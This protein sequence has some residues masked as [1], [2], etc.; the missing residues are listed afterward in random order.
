MN[1]VCKI[2]GSEYPADTERSA[3]MLLTIV[4]DSPRAGGGYQVSDDV[5]A[6]ILGLPDKQKALLSTWVVNHR[7]QR[8][9]LPE[10]TDA[11]IASAT[12]GDSLQVHERADRLLR[13][14]ASLAET[15]A[16][17]VLINEDIH[18]A[19]AW[20]ESVDWLEVNYLLNYLEGIGWM[21]VTRTLGGLWSSINVAGYNRIAEQNTKVD[22]T[23][24]FVAM[25]FDESMDDA[26]EIG[27]K[28]AIVEAGYNPLR[29]DRK[30]HINKID[31]E[32]IAELRR[33]KFLVADFT[34]GDSGARGG[35]YYE[36]GFAHGLG[37]P[38]IFSCRKDAEN[39]LHF[40][41]SH[42]NHIIWVD[43]KDLREKLKNRILAV[44]GEG[45]GAAKAP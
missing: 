33:S 12:N 15:V 30:D 37:L 41:T 9:H 34:H 18:A 2:W 39:S 36:A 29:I 44:I 42:Y 38:V 21:D 10:I 6:R 3:Q 20:S 22:S 1:S 23:Q 5:A 43:M 35:V 17:S 40:D 11:V 31:D 32:I 4:L 19:Y 25:W 7:I 26:F 24:A 28:S 16:H 14:I 8:V 27:I 45:P 13:F